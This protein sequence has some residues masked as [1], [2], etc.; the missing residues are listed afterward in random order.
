MNLTRQGRIE[1]GAQ[2]PAQCAAGQLFLKSMGSGSPVL[3]V[4]TQPNTWTAPSDFIAGSG[5]AITGGSIAADDAVVPVYY[6]GSGSPTIDCVAGRDFYVDVTAGGLYYCNATGHW[7]A[8]SAAG[9]THAAGDIT[10]GTLS[11]ALLPAGVATTGQANTFAAGQKQSVAHSSTTAGLRIV[12][13]SGDPSSAQDGDVWYNL[14]TGKFRR[15]ENG[16]ASDWSATGGSASHNLLSST[17]SDVTA[18]GVVRGDVITGQGTSATWARLAL[19]AAGSYLRSNGTDL[20]YSTI[21]LGDLPSGYGWSSLANVPASFTPSLHAAT[22]QNGGADEIATATAAANAIPKAGAGGTLAAGWLPNPSST[23]L[24]GVR[25]LAAGSHLWINA[26]S[27]AGVPSATQPACGD[28]SNAAA[29][30]STDTTNAANI[31]SGTLAAAR[32]PAN[33]RTRSIGF[34]FTGSAGAITNGTLA[35]F[36]VPFAC[37]ISAYNVTVDT[38]TVTFDV[39]KAASGTSIPTSANSIVAAAAPQ[40]STGTAL[41]STSL[42]GWNTTVS[43]NDIFGFKVTAVSGATLAS[44]VLECDQ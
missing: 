4:C 20:V 22:H 24:G 16:V 19:G 2:L 36:T 40:I 27:T 9:H 8:L 39:W 3:F 31:T 28:L 32:I 26:I 43:A 25:S 38:G 6:T 11:T 42:T 37:T 30:C 5:I 44:L 33:V 17:H 12:P 14:T 21:P 15:R 18:A 7:Q 10:S 35:Y 29:S 1:S 13:A 23:T 41:H 34:A